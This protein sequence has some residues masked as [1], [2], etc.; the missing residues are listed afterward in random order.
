VVELQH[1]VAE[2]LAD[3]EGRALEPVRPDRV[4]VGD[5]DLLVLRQRATNVHRLDLSVV[6]RRRMFHRADGCQRGLE[7]KP[8]LPDPPIS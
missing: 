1:L 3:P 7:A 6:H 5:D 2:R 8:P 4:I